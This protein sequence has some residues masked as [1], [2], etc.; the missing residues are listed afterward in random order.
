MKKQTNKKPQV[1]RT[2]KEFG[3]ETIVSFKYAKE[4]LSG[5]WTDIEYHLLQGETLWT[6]FATY[7]IKQN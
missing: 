3:T 4:K 6:P 7:Q 5:Y 1:I 2:C